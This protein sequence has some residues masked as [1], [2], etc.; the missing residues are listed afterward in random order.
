M[1]EAPV[2]DLIS[3]LKLGMALFLTTGPDGTARLERR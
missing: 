1:W 2:K 3:L